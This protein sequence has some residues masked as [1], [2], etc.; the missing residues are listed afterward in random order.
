MTET[1]QL[2]LVKHLV[3][4]YQQGNFAPIAM[5][6]SEDVVLR[7]TIAEGTPLSGIFHGPQGVAE[8]FSKIP[9]VVETNAM[10]VLNFLVGGQQ[11][12]VTGRE[13]LTVKKTGRQMKEADWVMLFTFTGDKISEVVIVEDTTEI[14]RAYPAGGFEVG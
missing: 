5:A 11:V 14:A 4:Q 7:P 8:Y 10:E 12:A 3:E 13:T 2:N 1:E 9:E 6:L